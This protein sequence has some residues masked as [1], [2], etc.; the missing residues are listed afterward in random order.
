[1]KC[2]PIV[3]LVG[4]LAGS[5]SCSEEEWVAIFNGKDLTGW[6]PKF[7]GFPLG[8]NVKETFSVE[9]GLLKVSYENYEEWDSLFGHL[10][11]EEELSH[12]KLR[13]EYR[14]V[15]E[16]VPG[17]P[18]WARRNNGVMIH[19]QSAESMDIEQNFPASIEVQLLG[20][21]GGRA[22]P[23]ANV[24]TPETQIVY[25]GEVDTRHCVKSSSKTF[26]GDQWVT[27]EIEVRGSERI[28]HRVNGELVF[29]Y[30]CPQLDDGTLLDKGT[31]SLQAESAP[32]EFRRIELLR[33]EE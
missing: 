6:T 2:A 1:M 33:L 27:V 12:Y 23:T 29:E 21:L 32:T 31:I 22:R 8:E 28:T 11:F 25:E 4:L 20:G 17:G 9:D 19:G 3:C 30:E 16:Q 10:F 14:F 13:V 18:G 26:E 5:A 24:C 15:G 7:R